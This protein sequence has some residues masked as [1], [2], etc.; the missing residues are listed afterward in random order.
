MEEQAAFNLVYKWLPGLSV[1]E[2]L[3]GFS[4]VSRFRARLG[5]EGFEQ[6]FDQV[7]EQAGVGTSLPIASTLSTPPASA[8]GLRM[9][10]KPHNS[11]Y[12]KLFLHVGLFS[13]NWTYIMKKF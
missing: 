13:E 10:H 11:L 4:T 12:V 6:L 1:Q 7:V 2:L 9:R 5:A 3:P 8:S